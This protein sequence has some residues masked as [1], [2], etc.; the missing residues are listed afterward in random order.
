MG[1]MPT[2]QFRTSEIPINKCFS[3]LRWPNSGTGVHVG[4]SPSLK[5][6]KI[7][8]RKN[9]GNSKSNFTAGLS[10]PGYLIR[11]CLFSHPPVAGI[12]VSLDHPL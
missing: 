1:S 4:G 12:R 6:R 5:I 9:L 11:L 8:L 3:P 10:S 7:L 2:A